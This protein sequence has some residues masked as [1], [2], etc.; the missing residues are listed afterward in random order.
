MS[1][2]L[3]FKIRSKPEGW[4]RNDVEEQER[5]RGGGAGCIISGIGAEGCWDDDKRSQVNDQ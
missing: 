3:S 4:E 1:R 2:E 5:Q